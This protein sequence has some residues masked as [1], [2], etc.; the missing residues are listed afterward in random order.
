MKRLQQNLKQY[1]WYVVL[2]PAFFVLHGFVEY[3]SFLRFADA[4]L[5]ALRY[6]LFSLAVFFISWMIFRDMRKGAV[7]TVAWMG[8]YLFFGAVYDF[9]KMHSPFYLL[10]KYSFLLPFFLLLFFA[11]FIY[12]WKVKRTF[13][14]LTFFLNCLFIVYITLDIATW[15]WKSMQPEKHR[16]GFYKNLAGNKMNLPGSLPKPDI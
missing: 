14:K 12:L 13:Y 1:P 10:W 5:L 6:I 8:F 7:I 9:L 3:F 15:I 11:L 16:V 2:L 4:A